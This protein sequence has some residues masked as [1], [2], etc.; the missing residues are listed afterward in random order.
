MVKTDS[1]AYSFTAIHARSM[2]KQAP[3]TDFKNKNKTNYKDTQITL[4]EGSSSAFF[5]RS[6]E[7][8]LVCW[9]ILRNNKLAGHLKDIYIKPSSTQ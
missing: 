5:R 4:T 3:V 9:D 2:K 1:V 8:V 7:H 6:F